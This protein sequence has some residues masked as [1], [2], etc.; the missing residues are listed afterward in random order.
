MLSL[1]DLKI[2]VM[3]KRVKSVIQKGSNDSQVAINL[4]DILFRHVMASVQM[5]RSSVKLNALTRGMIGRV[6]G[7]TRD[8]TKEYIFGMRDED[9]KV[10][11][12]DIEK[13]LNRRRM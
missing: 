8:G 6:L 7:Q 10:L 2:P 11:L 9:I 1:K 13:E 4:V 5:D 12:N 3:K